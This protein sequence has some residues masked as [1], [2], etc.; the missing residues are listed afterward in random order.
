LRLSSRFSSKLRPKRRRGCLSYFFFPLAALILIWVL[1]EPILVLAGDALVE[2]DG[3]TKADAIVVLGGD[4]FGTRILRGAE[5]VK[6]GYASRLLVSGP[7]DLLGYES[8]SSIVYASRKGYPASMFEAIPLPAEA[9]STRGE[10]Q[11]IGRK[12]KA[13]DIKSIDLVTSNYHT[14]RAAW[15]WRKINPDLQIHV[16]PASDPYFSPETWFRTRTGQKTF[17]METTKTIASHLGD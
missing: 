1:R 2:D 3:A 12:L 6:A 16:V 5:L 14:R 4:A 13:E 15:L 7:S 17:F 8:D 9:D 10:A 11:Y